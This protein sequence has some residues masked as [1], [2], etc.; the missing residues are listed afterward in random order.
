IDARESIEAALKRPQQRMK[1]RAPSLEDRLHVKAERSCGCEHEEQHEGDLEPAVESHDTNPFLARRN[2]RLGSELFR[3]KQGVDEIESD[4]AGHDR[5]ENKVK[6]VRLT[7]SPPNG[8][9][10]PSG[11]KFPVQG[12]DRQCPTWSSA[13]LLFER[14]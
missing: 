3:M 11:R 12:R 4:S 9:K 10:G 5:A 14:T 2:P 8:R 13:P 1:P 6:H 7:R